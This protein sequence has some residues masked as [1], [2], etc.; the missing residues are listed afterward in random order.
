[1]ATRNRYTTIFNEIGRRSNRSLGG[2][3][4]TIFIRGLRAI[5]R[6]FDVRT[7]PV[8]KYSQINVAN[9]AAYIIY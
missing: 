2:N 1:M 8:F 3:T 9:P 4:R 6:P 7:R 5:I